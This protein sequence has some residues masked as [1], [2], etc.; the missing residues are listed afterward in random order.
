[1]FS[2]DFKEF[3][4]LLN[5][6]RVRYLI[7]GGYAVAYHGHPR[8]TKDLD[9]WLEVSKANA[10]RMVAVLR[11]FGFESLGL[12][13]DAFL[14]PD[15]VIQLGYPPLRIDL[16]IGL[17]TLSFRKC[18]AA[19]GVAAIDGISVNFIDLVGLLESKREA[20]RAQD[21]ADVEHLSPRK[22]STTGEEAID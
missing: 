1:M 14:E 4:Q 22:K 16:L 20:G 17:R 12:T 13:V 21:L 2:P 15:H 9:I 11:D 8:Y 18:F 10:N 6:H 19:R 7:V 5:S 3:L